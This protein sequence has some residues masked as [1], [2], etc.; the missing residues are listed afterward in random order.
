MSLKRISEEDA[1]PFLW[2]TMEGE[3]LTLDE[4]KTAHIFNSMKMIFNHLAKEWGGKPVWFT[5]QYGDYEVRAAADP[6]TLA[7]VVVR[8]LQEIEKRGDLPAR[9]VEPYRAIVDQLRPKLEPAQRLLLPSPSP[10][11]RLA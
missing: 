8:F 5:K 2:R 3:V 7:G 11:R 6:A 9:Y 10:R 4:M 1:R